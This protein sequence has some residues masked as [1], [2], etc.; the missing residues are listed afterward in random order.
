MRSLADLSQA[1]FALARVDASGAKLLGTPFAV[2]PEHVATCLHVTGGDDQNLAIVIPRQTSLADYQD[3]T[4]A[5]INSA[6]VKIVAVDPVNDLCV[7][8]V[9]LEGSWSFSYSIGSSDSVRPG[10]EVTTLGFPHTDTGRL[11]LTQQTSTIGAR[12]LVESKGSKSKHLVL[13]IQARPGQS[14]GP[15]FVSHGS[16]VVAM[17]VGS[18]APGGGGGIS[19][20]GVDPATLHTTT[21]AVS[22][23]YLK[24]MLQ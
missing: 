1:V 23:E 22:T 11:V 4:D 20:G 24:A 18:Y 3:T 2:G 9:P 12:I 10:I 17:L 13:N 7:L 5:R 19:L 8:R 14:G 21:H 6:P 15:V 16:M